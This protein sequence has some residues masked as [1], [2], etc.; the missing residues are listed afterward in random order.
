[1]R[2]IKEDELVDTVWDVYKDNGLEHF[3]YKLRFH[4]DQ[5]EIIQR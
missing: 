1:M 2:E 5:V 4:T 3:L